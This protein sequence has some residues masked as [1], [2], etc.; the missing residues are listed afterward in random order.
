MNTIIIFTALKKPV[1]YLIELNV[2]EK[3]LPLR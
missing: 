2:G 3:K 1:D